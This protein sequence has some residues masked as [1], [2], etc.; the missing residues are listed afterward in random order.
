MS[1]NQPYRPYI[2]S[3]NPQQWLNPSAGPSRPPSQNPPHNSVY[4]PHPASR[5]LSG[6]YRPYGAPL[7]RLTCGQ[8]LFRPVN[9]DGYSY[10]Q[11]YAETSRP[12][13]RPRGNEPAANGAGSAPNGAMAWRNCSVAGC[14]FVGPGDQVGI[15]E[16]DRHLI[17]PAGHKVERSEEEEKFAK[18]TG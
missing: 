5:N 3:P 8:A 6:G 9:P 11:N 17:F 7:N 1:Y 15:H 16:G 4:Q 2:T 18:R 12:N 14:S 10:S 13:K